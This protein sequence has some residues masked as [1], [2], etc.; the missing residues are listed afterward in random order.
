[1]KLPIDEEVYVAIREE[2]GVEWADLS[3]IAY[4]E[5]A[6]RDNARSS[7][8]GQWQKANPVKRIDLCRL[9]SV[10]RERGASLPID[11]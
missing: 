10:S 7:G 4:T 5:K 6:A 8:G 11:R 3:T 1:M 9:A 2:R